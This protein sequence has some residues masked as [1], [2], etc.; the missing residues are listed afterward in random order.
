MNYFHINIEN[1]EKTMPLIFKPLSLEALCSF[2]FLPFSFFFFPFSFFLSSFS[3]VVIILFG[4]LKQV[5][6]V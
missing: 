4:F 2:F 5:F 3:V 6:K 1:R